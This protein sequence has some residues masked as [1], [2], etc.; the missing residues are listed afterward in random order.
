MK[1]RYLF[2]LCILPNL[3][4]NYIEYTFF[5]FINYPAFFGKIFISLSVIL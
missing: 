3:S 1:V 5:I 4:R 2:V